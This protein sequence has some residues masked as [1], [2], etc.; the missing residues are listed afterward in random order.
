MKVN[1][2]T[3]Q[4]HSKEGYTNVPL[5]QEA[6][7]GIPDSACHELMVDNVLEFIPE[8]AS[9]SLV[10]KIR[11]GGVVDIRSPDARE[12]MRQYHLGSV[13]FEEASSLLA[14]GRA[15]ISTLAQ[16]KS[17]LESNGLHVDFAGLNGAFYRITATR[18]Q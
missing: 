12:I 5:I 10:K 16:T 4:E 6:L 8:D 13:S 7:Q 15:R 17:F 1:L 2:I 9:V 3:A 18:P 14:G 11:K